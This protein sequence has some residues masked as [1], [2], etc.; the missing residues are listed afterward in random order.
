MHRLARSGFFMTPTALSGAAMASH[1][2]VMFWRAGLSGY[3]FYHRKDLFH[4]PSWTRIGARL[5]S[6]ASAANMLV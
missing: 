3:V 6:R 4:M 5:A 2:R 1:L